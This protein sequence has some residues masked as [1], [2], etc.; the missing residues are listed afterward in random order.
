MS[1]GLEGRSSGEQEKCS[2]NTQSGKCP[3]R[4]EKASLSVSGEFFPLTGTFSTFP[5]LC[6][7]LQHLPKS[8]AF[9]PAAEIPVCICQQPPCLPY[10]FHACFQ[11]CHTLAWQNKLQKLKQLLTLIPP[12]PSQIPALPSLPLRIQVNPFSPCISSPNA[13][14]SSQISCFF[15]ISRLLSV[16]FS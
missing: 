10:T 11:P 13:L 5:F 2:A 12:T 3:A 9:L 15:L 8:F 7:Y 14:W 6:P 1:P 16:F 4:A